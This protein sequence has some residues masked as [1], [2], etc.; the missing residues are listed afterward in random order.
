MDGKE[1]ARLAH[2][3]CLFVCL[4]S[5]ME[6]VLSEVEN[7]IQSEAGIDDGTGTCSARL[8]YL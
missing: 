8:Q 5:V 3:S 1:G 4:V 6:R 2:L 7:W